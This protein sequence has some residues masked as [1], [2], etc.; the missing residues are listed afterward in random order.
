MILMLAFGLAIGAFYSILVLFMHFT[1]QSGVRCSLLIR[2]SRLN[3]FNSIS[4]FPLLQRQV[5]VLGMLLLTMG[6]AG[7]FVSGVLLDMTSRHSLLTKLGFGGLLISYVW[8]ILAGA[9]GSSFIVM[10]LPSSCVVRV[11]S[12]FA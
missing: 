12:F 3:C 6:V 8:F 4:F 2:H 9:A 5:G 10:S 1:P 7:S 11:H